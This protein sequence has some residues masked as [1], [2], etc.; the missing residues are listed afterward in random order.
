LLRISAVI[1]IVGLW[2]STAILKSFHDTIRKAALKKAADGL[3]S[4]FEMNR[5]LHHTKTK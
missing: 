4:P 1:V 3:P 2:Q 5:K